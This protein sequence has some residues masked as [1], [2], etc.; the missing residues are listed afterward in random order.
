MT[1]CF[2]PEIFSCMV[3]SLERQRDFIYP[4][5]VALPSKSEAREGKGI[6]GKCTRAT[7][8]MD[9]KIEA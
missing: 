1:V 7:V 6:Y 4:G 5:F 3:V 9:H 2:S 8:V